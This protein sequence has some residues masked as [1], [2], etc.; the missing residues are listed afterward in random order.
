MLRCREGNA[1]DS[2]ALCS[3]ATARCRSLSP[4]VPGPR[5]GELQILNG[6]DAIYSVWLASPRWE[7]PTMLAQV[8]ADRPRLARVQAFSRDCGYFVYTR[9]LKELA[10]IRLT[11]SDRAAGEQRIELTHELDRSASSRIWPS[12]DGESALLATE[13]GLS[14]LRWSRA[15]VTLLEPRI[16]VDV[17]AG[18]IDNANAVLHGGIAE[19][20]GEHLLLKV[21]LADRD[22]RVRALIDEDL[23]IEAQRGSLCFTLAPDGQSALLTAGAG[24]RLHPAFAQADSRDVPLLYDLVSDHVQVLIPRPSA[25]ISKLF[26]VVPMGTRALAFSLA[27]NDSGQT[28]SFVHD[29]RER[30]PLAVPLVDSNRRAEVSANG[31]AAA[32]QGGERLDLLRFPARRQPWRS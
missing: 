12:P 21:S 7:A 14:L 24:K 9:G 29:L 15:E 30:Y 4:L 22:T 26:D 3:W 28:R 18:W 19:R 13:S 27:V 17:G 32:F 5:C 25:G 6:P 31:L 20:G 11:P 10:Q 16:S 8:P 23:R 2:T 1:G